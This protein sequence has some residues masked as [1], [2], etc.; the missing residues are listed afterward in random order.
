MKK[1]AFLL[2]LIPCI[3]YGL[4]YKSYSLDNQVNG[5]GVALTLND[6]N[7]YSLTW[8][9][10]HHGYMEATG[11]VFPLSE[12]KYKIKN[13][14]ITFSDT[15]H[16]GSY[17]TAYKDSLI[18]MNSFLFFKND[19]FQLTE[20]GGGDE[21]K[22]DYTER[23]A[24]AVDSITHLFQ[25]KNKVD[26]TC[27]VYQVK[28]DEFRTFTLILNKDSKYAYTWDGRTI[29]KGVYTIDKNII[30][31]QDGQTNCVYTLGVGT[32]TIEVL[33]LPLFWYGD[34]FFR[35]KDE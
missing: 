21:S 8:A 14:V 23:S 10:I 4:K 12:G 34:D 18:V 29:S 35:I 24:H 15:Y 28:T 26:F 7:T 11:F 17:Q 6:D 31:L 20:T 3:S 32:A 1:I 30:Y 19:S 5:G 22:Y 13:G 16:K 33:S 27:G 25:R 2:L 9:V